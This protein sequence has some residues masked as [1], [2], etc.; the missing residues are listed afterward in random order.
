MICGVAALNQSYISS[1]NHRQWK[2]RSA[3]V[4]GLRL[5]TTNNGQGKGWV[6]TE[7]ET[8]QF[9]ELLS[10]MYTQTLNAVNE[11]VS[12]YVPTPLSNPARSR[13]IRSLDIWHFEPHR[14]PEEEI[15][16]CTIILF[17]VLYCIEGM[18]EA[19]GI[20]LSQVSAFVHH[21]RQIY[22]YENTY[23]NFEHALDVLQAIQCY[24]STA[25][26]V[27]PVTILL[28]PADRK[29]RPRLGK[30]THEPLVRTLGLREIFALYIAAIGHDVGHP[31]VTNVFMKNAQTPLSLVF[32][33]RSALE[34]LHCQLLLR[35]MRMHG[36]GVLLDDPE[37]GVRFKKLLLQAVL[38]TDMSVH[39]DFMQRFQQELN[40][41]REP[42]FQRQILACQALLK[43]ADISNPSRPFPVAEHWASALMQEWSAQ[44]E[45]EEHF[46]LQQSV[47]PA[48]DP[49][50]AA[51]SQIFFISTF[52]KPLLLASMGAIPEM[53]R[54]HQHCDMN[55]ERWLTRK[56]D[57]ESRNDISPPNP[58]PPP[59]KSPRQP[60]DFQSAFPLTLPSGSSSLLP[61][62]SGTISTANS[63]ASSESDPTSPC[64]SIFS[65]GIF[66]PTSDAVA[67][68]PSIV[69]FTGGNRRHTPSS[70]G[71]SSG[72]I[73]NAN[74]PNNMQ[75]PHEAIRA[76]GRLS[77]RQLNKASHRNSWCVPSSLPNG[78]GAGPNHIL[79][80]LGI[81]GI[82]GFGSSSIT[83]GFP[84]LSPLSTV[85]SESG[86]S[87]SPPTPNSVAP[88]PSVP[89]VLLSNGGKTRSPISPVPI[90]I[91]VNR[92][93][94]VQ[95]SMIGAAAQ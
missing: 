72:S 59:P 65:T 74:S 37:N 36:L 42:L 38:A 35:V 73:L 6:G 79:V 1:H 12:E 8:T 14:L 10:E 78:N 77:M 21:L 40:G 31:G 67:H 39:A 47:Q 51:K 76:A 86:S 29:W 56:A 13:L 71:S 27:P 66:S 95:S 90:V 46:R 52:A 63:T 45:L 75:D 85:A 58:T 11:H 16:A 2:R 82:G 30:Y 68:S 41:H 92:T 43:N 25:H 48:D 84:P 81:S 15:L 53:S 50:S 83:H 20:P 49:L 80:G 9:A 28:Q 34:Q 55:L 19:V 18:E 69:N 22:R 54:Y 23:H 94:S 87:Y 44:A 5:A 24:L 33:G 4:G 70:S 26:M 93:S 17:E 3:D 64:E 60:S 32:D 57:L 88:P 89:P 91:P 61:T 7:V 62:P